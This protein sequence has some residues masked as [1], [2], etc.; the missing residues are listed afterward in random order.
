MLTEF[1][2]ERA[3]IQTQQ[4]RRMALIVLGVIEY[5][6]EQGRFYLVQDHVVQVAAGL[7]IECFQEVLDRLAGAVLERRR[8]SLGCLAPLF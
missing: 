7:A 5:C 3:T 1:L 6:L 4:R 2:A 8:V